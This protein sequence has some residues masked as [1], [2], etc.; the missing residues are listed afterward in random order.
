MK[1]ITTALAKNYRGV[2]EGLWTLCEAKADLKF[3]RLAVKVGS[4][5]SAV[6]PHALITGRL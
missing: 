4:V 2:R 5:A 1:R 6:L 3:D